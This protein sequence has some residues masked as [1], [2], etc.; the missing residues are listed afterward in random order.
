MT[1][2]PRISVI[3]PAYNA[4]NTIDHCLNAL[5]DQTIAAEDY[6]IIVVDDGSSDETCG[7]V[8]AHAGVQLVTQP[9]AGPAAARNLGA[10]R[11]KGDVLLF[12]D[13]DCAPG[14][15]WIERMLGPFDN[16]EIVG[17]K[18]A[19]VTRQREIVARFVQLEYETRYQ[20]MARHRYIDFIDTYAAGYRRGVFLAN[21]G[22]DSIF[23]SASV[24]DQELSFRLARQGYKM[25]FVPEASVCHL[26]HPG[27][28]QAYWRRKFRIGYWKVLVTKRHPEKVWLD[29]HTPQTLKAQ[30][31]LVGLMLF[32]L[33]GAVVWL[34]MLWGLAVAT[35]LY[36]PSTL[37]FVIRAGRKDP[38]VALVSPGLLLLR[39]LALGTGYA[40]GLVAHRGSGQTLEEMGVPQKGAM[41]RATGS[42]HSRSLDSKGSHIHVKRAID[43]VGGAIGLVFSVPLVF[44]SAIVIKLDSRGPIFFVQNRVGENG[45][46]FKIYK[47]RTMVENAEGLVDQSIDLDSLD[48]LVIKRRDD[49]R[50]TRVG[51][52]LRRWSIDEVPQFLNVLKGEMSLVGPRPEEVRI[53]GRYNE[54]HRQRLRVKPGLTGPMQVNGRGDLSLEER[55]HLEMDYIQ[56]YSVARDLIILLKTIPAVILRNGSY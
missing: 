54:W 56:N 19:Y 16:R 51:R 35:L 43:V 24:E 1:A 14:R 50:I 48:T 7:R 25:V 33:L 23:P 40:V 37:P 44:V 32:F 18:G 3:V 6:E 22:F 46:R 15:E 30:I 10:Q 55:V 47:L 5:A 13:A 4:A 11:A 36:A 20:R 17:V 31:V 9:H 12:T 8:K 49:P 29:S 21:G 2:Q 26:G 42:R 45:R 39:A 34:P 52:F 41:L 53:V 38:L 28:I 27:S